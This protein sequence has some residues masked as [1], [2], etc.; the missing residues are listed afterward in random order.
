MLDHEIIGLDD[1]KVL[2]DAM[3]EDTELNM[4]GI[5]ACEKMIVIAD[6]V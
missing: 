2:I 5:L 6:A 4:T 1:V 3:D